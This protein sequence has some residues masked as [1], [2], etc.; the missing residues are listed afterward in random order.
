MFVYTAFYKIC[1]DLLLK[2]KRKHKIMV[3]TTKANPRQQKFRGKMLPRIKKLPEVQKGFY[4]L[5]S[6]KCSF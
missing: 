6:L 3:N 5:V 1:D 2:K 4:K